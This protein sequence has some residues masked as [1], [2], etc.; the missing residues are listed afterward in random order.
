MYLLKKGNVSVR[1]PENVDVKV[2]EIPLYISNLISELE[3]NVNPKD[4]G[5]IYANFQK[6]WDIHAPLIACACCG[7][8]NY[9]MG[10]HTYQSVLVDN[11]HILQCTPSFVDTMEIDFSKELR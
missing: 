5:R 7:V 10:N 8:K 11:L 4:L 1:D 9:V 3:N 6:Q 2:E